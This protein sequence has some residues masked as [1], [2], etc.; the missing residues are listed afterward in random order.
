LTAGDSLFDDADMLGSMGLESPKSVGR[1]STLQLPDSPP[2]QP[3]ARSV[4][5]NLLQRS[6]TT[7]SQS[8][9]FTSS[10][11]KT[12]GISV[13]LVSVNISVN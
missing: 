13:V 9:D 5:D 8:A 12:P 2:S 6:K 7:S 1:K 10:T 4:M 3:G 11:L